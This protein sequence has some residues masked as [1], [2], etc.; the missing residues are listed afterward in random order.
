M[1]SETCILSLKWS[2]LSPLPNT[3][4][5]TSFSEKPQSSGTVFLATFVDDMMFWNINGPFLAEI[6]KAK[7]IPKNTSYSKHNNILESGKNG[8]FVKT[9]AR[10]NGQFRAELQK[11][12]INDFTTWLVFFYSKL[13]VLWFFK[14]SKGWNKLVFGSLRLRKKEYPEHQIYLHTKMKI[15][16]VPLDV[17][18]E[19][20]TERCSPR[21]RP[22]DRFWNRGSDTC[23]QAGR[24]RN[25]GP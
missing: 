17:A 25:V 5:C 9:I 13:S 7:N 14:F 2:L 1:P 3:R 12:V 23:R 11:H 24:E 10:Q 4:N 16:A 6:Q 22:G 8:H 20:R 15:S 19:R 21:F 18:P